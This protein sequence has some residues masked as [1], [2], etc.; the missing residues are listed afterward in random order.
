MSTLCHIQQMNELKNNKT[1]FIVS[2]LAGSPKQVGCGLRTGESLSG[3]PASSNAHG[4]FHLSSQIPWTPPSGPALKPEPPAAEASEN[5]FSGS[6]STWPPGRRYRSKGEAKSIR[7]LQSLHQN[8][9]CCLRASPHL[10][11]CHLSGP[12]HHYVYCTQFLQM[13]A[14]RTRISLANM[15]TL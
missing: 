12:C 13:W 11:L 15:Q 8:C 10:V 4:R 14:P 3:L 6:F 9:K 2:T 7:S 5:W 1:V